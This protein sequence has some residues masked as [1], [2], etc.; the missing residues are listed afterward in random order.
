MDKEQGVDLEGHTVLITGAN[1]GIGRATATALARRGARVH[2]ACRSRARAQPVLDEITAAH[3]P[4][5][6]SF[7]ALDLSDLTSVRAGAEAYLATGEPLHVL[8]NNAGVAGQRGQTADGFELA[9]GVNHLG[10]FLFTT[11]L[12][13]ALAAGA[14]ARVVVVAS[15]AHYGATG[16]D[17]DALRR[18]T[19]SITGMAEYSVSKLCNVLFAQELARRVDAGITTYALHPGVIASDI[20]RRLPWPLEPLAKS[21]MK[22]TVDGA[23]TSVYCASDP[24][25]TGDTGRYYD[26]CTERAPSERATPELAAEL[27]ERSQAWT[28]P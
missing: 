16:I 3:G 28:G 1:T 12:L 10:H 4:D 27:W 13:G 17:F 26:D 7:L 9:F 20:W 21:F 8:I 22:S 11:M 23:R 25:L 18:R 15:D 2:L 5:A 6:A 19:R 24:G 14:P